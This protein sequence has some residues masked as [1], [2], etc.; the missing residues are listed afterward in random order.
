MRFMHK[1]FDRLL[2]SPVVGGRHREDLVDRIVYVSAT[3]SNP[4]ALAFTTDFVYGKA[5]G[6]LLVYERGSA[7]KSMQANSS[8][9]SKASIKAIAVA[10]LILEKTCYA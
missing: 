5:V 6:N 1:L 8:T 9:L 10:S 3:G 7:L 2:L 4:H